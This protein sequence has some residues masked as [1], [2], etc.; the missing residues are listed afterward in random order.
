MSSL[1]I[2]SSVFAAASPL[3]AFRWSSVKVAAS[4]GLA[5]GISA[6]VSAAEPSPHRVWGAKMSS[7]SGTVDAV[8]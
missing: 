3:D 5:V 8:S 6:A 1:R 7:V 4:S 2:A